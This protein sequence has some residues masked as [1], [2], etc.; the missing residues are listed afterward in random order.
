MLPQYVELSLIALEVIPGGR[1]ALHDRPLQP[2][3]QVD[4]TPRRA[5]VRQSFRPANGWIEDGESKT[6]TGIP[7]PGSRS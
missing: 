5:P 6:S 2:L 1:E 7:D 4:E 3:D